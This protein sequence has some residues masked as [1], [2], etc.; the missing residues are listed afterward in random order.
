LIRLFS[1]LHEIDEF[2]LGQN[3]ITRAVL[4]GM[5]PAIQEMIGVIRTL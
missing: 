1:D 4:K 2:S 3:L 5:E